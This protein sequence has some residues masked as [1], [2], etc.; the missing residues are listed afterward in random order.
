[1]VYDGSG[2]VPPA[3]LLF[4]EPCLQLDFFAQAGRGGLAGREFEVRCDDQG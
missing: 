1:M 3:A 4:A 2:D